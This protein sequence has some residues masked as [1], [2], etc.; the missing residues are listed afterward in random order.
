MAQTIIAI[1]SELFLL[2]IKKKM[3][4][5]LTNMPDYGK[6]GKMWD[7]PHDCGT[8]DTYVGCPAWDDREIKH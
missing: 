1:F 5:V 8:V 2:E 3:W 7:F 6:Q 4:D